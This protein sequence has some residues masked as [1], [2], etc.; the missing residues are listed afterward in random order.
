MLRTANTCIDAHDPYAQARWWDQLL[1]DHVLDPEASQ[2]DD[3]VGLAG[4]GGRW[5]IFLKVPEEKTVKNRMHLCLRPVE[6][7]RDTEVARVLALGASMVD[8]LREG[9]GTSWAVLADPE[10]NEFCVLKATAAE[11][12]ISRGA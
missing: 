2:D 8:D 5:L 4:P 12:G 3:E 6:T 9:E 10:G 1:D 7:D 11:D